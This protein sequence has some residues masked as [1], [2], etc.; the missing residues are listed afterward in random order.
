MTKTRCCDCHTELLCCDFD[1]ANKLSLCLGCWSKLPTATI[2]KR[3]HEH[4]K[5]GHL[6][7]KV[8]A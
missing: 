8:K 7:D 6:H 1:A 5:D 3:S 4:D 2:V